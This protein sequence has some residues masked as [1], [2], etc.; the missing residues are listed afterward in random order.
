MDKKDYYEVLGVSKTASDT[1]IKSA[2]RRLAKQYHP[3]VNKEEGAAEK[4][5]EIGEAYQVL[6]DPQ[7]RK[8]Y[9]QF[10]HAAFQ[11]GAG[12]GF[13]GGF[14]FGD[15]DLGDIFGD[16]FG[17][18]FG[19]GGFSSSSRGGNRPQKGRDSLISVKI[20]FE[21]AVFGTKKSIHLDLVEECDEC[22]GK[23]GFGE[24]T[25]SNC[26]GRGVVQEVSNTIFGQFAT[27][28]SCS[29]CDGTG[30]TYD[31]VCSTCRGAGKVKNKKEISIDIPAGIDHG[32]QLRLAG[33][34]NAGV[35]GGPNGDLYVEIIVSNHNYYVRDDYDIYLEVP[36]TVTEA[37]LGVRKEIPTLYGN[38]YLNIPAG[39]NS[40]DKH[41]I[42]DKGVTFLNSKKKGDMYIVLKVVIPNRLSKDQVKLVNEL[43]KTTLNDGKEFKEFDKFVKVNNG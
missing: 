5:K 38:I 4:F 41:R 30:H 17:Q 20:S 9:D 12:G 6:S 35:N 10:G 42:K 13:Q 27:Q 37:L 31:K 24:H 3:D 29:K 16:L 40:G 21:E 34:G 39:S 14:D 11:G 7:K 26:N 15:I 18:G 23:G 28:R 22:H 43:A 2:F 25:C 36:I 19:F 33:K 32:K 8:Q 1:E